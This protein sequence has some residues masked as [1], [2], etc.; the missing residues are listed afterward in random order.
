VIGE[1]ISMGILFRVTTDMSAYWAFA[2]VA[3]IG[4]LF[5]FILMFFI[6]EPQLRKTGMQIAKKAVEK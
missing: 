6:T 4:S 3:G 1:L 2:L 5:A